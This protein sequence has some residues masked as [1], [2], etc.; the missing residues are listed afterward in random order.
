MK[1][2]LEGN[3]LAGYE[4]MCRRLLSAVPPR[5]KGDV[6]DTVM[7]HLE[8]RLITAALEESGGNQVKAARLLGM[9]RNTLRRKVAQYD[10]FF[11][12]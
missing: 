8:C 7:R 6:H 12:K 9:H 3:W 5:A 10:E 4:S 2:M 11:A 1:T